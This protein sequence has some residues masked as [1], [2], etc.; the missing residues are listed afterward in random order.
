MV[1]RGHIDQGLAAAAHRIDQ[2]YST[3]IEHHNPMEPSATI[4]AWNGDEL[5]L[6]DATQW[7]MGARNSVAD[8][9]ALEREK[10]HIVSNF[11]GGVGCKV[12]LASSSHMRSPQEGG[13][14]A[15]GG[16][17]DA[18]CLRRAASSGD[19]SMCKWADSQA[20]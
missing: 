15:E 17:P 3:P 7:V 4:A 9:L 19:A 14:A 18:R 16:A 20:G 2:R 6:Y 1:V 13:K 11:V 5:S 8:M 10:V 12:S